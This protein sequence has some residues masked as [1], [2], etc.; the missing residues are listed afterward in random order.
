MLSRDDHVT[1]LSSLAASAAAALPFA[2]IPSACV[3]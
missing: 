2:I 1:L 3:S